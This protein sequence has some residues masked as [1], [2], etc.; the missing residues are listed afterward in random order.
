MPRTHFRYVETFLERIAPI[1]RPHP[2]QREFLLAGA[3]TQVLAC[4][5]RWGKTDACAV[6]ILHCLMTFGKSQ[7]L[8]LAPTLE[9]ARIL[10]ERVVSL[11]EALTEKTMKELKAGLRSS[12][13]PYLRFGEHKLSARSGHLGRSLRGNEAT[14]IVVDEAAFVPESLITEIAQPMMATTRGHLTMISTPNGRNHF[15]RYFQIGQRGELGVWSRTAPSSENPLVE[16]Q[17]LAIQRELVSERAFRT[18][19]EAEFFDSSGRV[20]SSDG[21]QAC[22][23]RT[24]P[25]S[26][27]PYTIGID[28]ARYSDFTSVAVLCGSNEAAHLVELQK[29]NEMAWG[30]QVERAARLIGRYPNA[31]VLCD[32]TGVGDPV[33]EMLQTALPH[34]SIEGIGF[35]SV[36]KRQL[37]DNLAFLMERG[38][39][40]FLPNPDLMRELEH[41]EAQTTLS[42]NVRLGSKS[43]YHDDLVIALALAARQ[44]NSPYF[45]SLA[46]GNRRRFSGERAANRNQGANDR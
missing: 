32:A 41:F 37:I 22:L 31:R 20:F 17:F 9:Q 5:R 3:R 23:I 29:W 35:T 45:P 43:G 21:I 7:Q 6:K 28:W 40:K 42:G 1:W 46:L 8:I 39:L 10:F 11:L 25:Q 4:G 15:Y 2:G 34:H 16:S 24:L 36:V 14:H 27:P 30:E 19:Y 18:E 33:I 13:Y 38:K 12:P 44:L 26:E